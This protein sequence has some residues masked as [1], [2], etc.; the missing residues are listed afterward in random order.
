M[1]SSVVNAIAYYFL[2]IQS[3]DKIGLL[4]SCIFLSPLVKMTDNKELAR[5]FITGVL[6]MGDIVKIIIA[7]A[8]G[9]FP[10]STLSE[11]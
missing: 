4:E 1:Q 8:S 6:H 2:R 3:L 7:F 5:D 9:Y 11:L 10:S